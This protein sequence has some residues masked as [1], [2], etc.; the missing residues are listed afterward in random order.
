MS[1]LITDI[2][3]KQLQQC[4]QWTWVLHGRRRKQEEMIF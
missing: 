1:E 3:K 2:K 4:A